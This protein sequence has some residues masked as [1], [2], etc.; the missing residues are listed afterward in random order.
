VYTYI[1]TYIHT[2]SYIHIYIYIYI[3]INI[4][5]NI[6]RIVN[7]DAEAR[8]GLRVEGT[9]QYIR[10]RETVGLADP[11]ATRE[12][13]EQDSR[14]ARV[15]E[16]EAWDTV[17][18]MHRSGQNK[19]LVVQKSKQIKKPASDVDSDSDMQ[20]EGRLRSRHGLEKDV[21]PNEGE[22]EERAQHKKDRLRSGQT[23]DS[24]TEFD[25]LHT[26]HDKEKKKPTQGKKALRITTTSS[27]KDS[28]KTKKIESRE[29]NQDD[30]RGRVW[31]ILFVYVCAYVCMYVCVCVC[32]CVGMF[33]NDSGKTKK[34]EPR[35]GNK[36]DE[37]GGV[38]C[39]LP[40]YVIYTGTQNVSA[41]SDD[42]H[43]VRKVIFCVCVC[44]YGYTHTYLSV[45]VYRY[46]HT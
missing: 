9:M 36:D 4:L 7:K 27:R 41:H 30:K 6:Y 25:P 15:L 10:W 1:H 46:K 35:E 5:H 45:C 33:R 17:K 18:G 23:D 42:D 28:G 40:V 26:A 21:V 39:K 16:K 13:N 44:V 20:R 12:R 3:Y 37:R 43:I 38:W 2:I 29:G 8:V 14:R 24:E 11:S 31:C 32:M 34:I 19:F 22:G